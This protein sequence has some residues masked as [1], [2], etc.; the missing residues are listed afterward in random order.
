MPASIARISEDKTTRQAKFLDK[1]GHE[2]CGKPHG[3]RSKHRQPQRLAAL[4]AARA[5]P[6]TGKG[7]DQEGHHEA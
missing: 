4:E 6:A 5:L 1:A 2:T 7:R 3:R